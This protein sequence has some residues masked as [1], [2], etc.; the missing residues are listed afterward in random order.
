MRHSG[1]RRMMQIKT[2]PR[3]SQGHSAT[4]RCHQARMASAC[5]M[6]WR[7]IRQN[8][9]NPSSPDL[10]FQ[11]G[12]HICLWQMASSLQSHGLSTETWILTTMQQMQL[13]AA[14]VCAVIGVCS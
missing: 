4:W 9:M 12:R 8:Q 10:Q 13:R 5:Q 1:T 14:Q 3:P 2:T 7:L 6:L 11:D